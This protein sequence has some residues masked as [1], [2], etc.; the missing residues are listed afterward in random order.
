M[1]L[2]AGSVIDPSSGAPRMLSIETGNLIASAD[3]VGDLV[4]G[5]SNG[6]PVYLRE[7]ARIEYGARNPHQ[8]VWYTPGTAATTTAAAAPAALPARRQR[9]CSRP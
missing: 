9:R 4:V 3:E 8:Y 5:V 1:G 7:V 6:R 2:P